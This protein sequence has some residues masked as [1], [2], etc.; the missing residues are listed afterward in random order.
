MIK[1]ITDTIFLQSY[2]EEKFD[3]WFLS[4]TKERRSIEDCVRQFVENKL[5][6]SIYLQ[7]NSGLAS[8][9]CSY[10]HF[11]DDLKRIISI[12]KKINNQD[13]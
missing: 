8:G 13:L 10:P 3:S 4:S 7:A 9:L 2:F 6:S 12:L 1:K 11:E 5:D